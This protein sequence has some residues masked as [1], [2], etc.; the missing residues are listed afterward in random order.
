MRFPRRSLLGSLGALG[1][2]G[3][4][5][6][7]ASASGRRLRATLRAPLGLQSY[8][9]R[10]FD[11]EAALERVRALGLGAVELYP[12]HFESA[13]RAA[14]RALKKAA[15]RLD[16]VLS[17]YGVVDFS[18]DEAAN[19]RW[20]D[21]AN[22][23]G[24]RTLS[25]DPDPDAFESLERLVDEYG[26]RVA[27]HNHGP[28]HR[29]GALDQVAAALEGRSARIGACV[30]TGHFVRSGEDP[31]RVLRTLGARVLGVHLKDFDAPGADARGT[32]L[33]A[34]R[35]DVEGVVRALEAIDFPP[36]GAL[37]LEYEEHPD[38]PMEDLERC[39]AVARE[40]LGP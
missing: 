20:F 10:A 29:Y 17:A 1:V 3:A 22:D 23:L 25:A 21:L 34:G 30:D 26:V 11:L 18:A 27:I 32:L 7:A 8:S 15:R 35:L 37:S 31:V 38:T 16:L 13:D 5:P 19:R 9:L 40:A 36:D 39:V 2:S 12:G 28:G 24:I 4:L 6:S 33:G 14:Q